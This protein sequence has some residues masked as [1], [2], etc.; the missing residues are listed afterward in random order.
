MIPENRLYA[1]DL[2]QISMTTF[3]TH[4]TLDIQGYRCDTEMLLS[5]LTKAALENSSL[6]STCDD[7]EGVA[8]SNT[9]REQLNEALVADLPADLPRDGVEIAID[10]H[11]DPFYGKTLEMQTYTCRDRAKKGTTHFFRIASASVL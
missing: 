11:D 7:L 1:K 4:L 5:V 8:D 9:R 10:F 2:H 6:Q 3:T